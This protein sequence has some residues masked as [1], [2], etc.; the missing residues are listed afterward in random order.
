[1]EFSFS[2]R[3]GIICFECSKKTKSKKEEI[4]PEVIKILRLFLKRDW[5]ILLKLKITE[6]YKNSLDSVSQKFLS[7]CQEDTLPEK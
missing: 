3:R 2:S 5:D 7:F 6:E 4:S 1:V